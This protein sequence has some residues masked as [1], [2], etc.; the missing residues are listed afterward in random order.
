MPPKSFSSLLIMY[1]TSFPFL[2]KL[3]CPSSPFKHVQNTCHLK[4]TWKSAPYALFPGKLLTKNSLDPCLNSP[5][6]NFSIHINLLLVRNSSHEDITDHFIARSCPL[7][8]LGHSWL[9]LQNLLC[10][11]TTATPLCF[12]LPVLLLLSFILFISCRCPHL[13]SGSSPRV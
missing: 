1:P 4:I 11:M 3:C 6:N 10:V 12:L 7:C 13:L 9:I 2:G 8:L 5:L